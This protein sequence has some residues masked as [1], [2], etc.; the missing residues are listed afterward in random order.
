M[1]AGRIFIGLLFLLAPSYAAPAV[2]EAAGHYRDGLGLMGS[3]PH[4]MGKGWG[5]H[6]SR[7]YECDS[8]CCN[9]DKMTPGYGWGMCDDRGECWW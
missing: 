4:T 8:G 6:C 5:Q 3:W 1:V 2:G 7:N 9:Y